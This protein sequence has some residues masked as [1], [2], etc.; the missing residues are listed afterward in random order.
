MKIA[1]LAAQMSEPDC[2]HW[3]GIRWAMDKLDIEYYEIDIRYFNKEQII[4]DLK[5]CN[6]DIIIYGLTDPFYKSYY[7]EIRKNIKG[8]IVWWYADYVDD[9][10]GVPLNID[11]RGY[12]DYICVSNDSQKEFWKEKTGIEAH[13]VAMAGTPV[14]E[15]QFDL[16]YNNDIVFIGNILS[17]DKLKM[18]ERL[19]KEIMLKENVT[20]I[21]ELN[22]GERMEVYRE[23]PKIYG[24]AKICLDASAVWYSNKYTSSRYYVISNCGGFSLCKKFPGCEELYPTGT[25]KVYYDTPDEFV[26]LKNY[27]FKNPKE[28]EKI[29]IKGLEHSRKY[30]TYINR[31][32]DILK[33]CKLSK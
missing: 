21:N 28:T 3:T 24:S 14:D 27:Y 17:G 23:M 10:F 30:H 4:K 15:I 13:F 20:V 18:R 19:L 12:V 8:K 29:S 32:N 5:E 31:I 22:Q 26:E 2:T 7:K 11:L 16:K 33:I 1:L 25:G 6:P 9:K